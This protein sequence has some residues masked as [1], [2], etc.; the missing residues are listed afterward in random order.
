MIRHGNVANRQRRAGEA[1]VDITWAFFYAQIQKSCCVPRARSVR[2]QCRLEKPARG[3]C[4]MRCS[5]LQFVYHSVCK[6]QSALNSRNT[7]GTPSDTGRFVSGPT[8]SHLP[9]GLVCAGRFS[10]KTD[11]NT[12]AG[13]VTSSPAF[14]S[15]AKLS[16]GTM[17]NRRVS[18]RNR[19]LSVAATPSP[20]SR[21][22]ASSRSGSPP[23]VR[24]QKSYPIGGHKTPSI[25][26]ARM[27]R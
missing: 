27:P 18:T 15:R 5:R 20:V 21:L 23:C 10:L 26:A 2:F 25:S 16:L 17:R 19:C 1:Q 13:R 22:R 11:R 7:R 14:V 8:Q 6:L 24:V 3:A 12:K 9:T 4:K